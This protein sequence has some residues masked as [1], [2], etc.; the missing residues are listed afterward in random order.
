MSVECSGDAICN[1]FFFSGS[2]GPLDI[3]AQP[4]FLQD[5]LT[6]DPRILATGGVLYAQAVSIYEMENLLDTT[7]RWKRA[8]WQA[9]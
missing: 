7:V 5:G 9:L 3:A 2:G 4:A 1:M 6:N 8:G